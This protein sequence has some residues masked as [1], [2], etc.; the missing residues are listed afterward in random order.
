[1][2][3]PAGGPAASA[4]VLRA[5]KLRALVGDPDLVILDEPSGGLDDDGVARVATDRRVS[6]AVADLESRALGPLSASQIAGFHA[7]ITALQEAS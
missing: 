4:F 5:R 3:S 1:M 7:V 2:N 6:E